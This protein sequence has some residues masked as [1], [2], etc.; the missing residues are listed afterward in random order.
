[1]ITKK[2]K[3]VLIVNDNPLSAEA[4]S[5]LL[6]KIKDSRFKIITDT[7]LS[8]NEACVAS[9]DIPINATSEN[10]DVPYDLYVVDLRM[11]VK[12]G[13]EF[14]EWLRNKRKS[15]K[16]VIITSAQKPSAM[17]LMKRTSNLFIQG[18]YIPIIGLDRVDF[19]QLEET[20]T[21]LLDTK[22]IGIIGGGQIGKELVKIL[23]PLTN[24]FVEK[25]LIYSRNLE[26]LQVEIDD[27]VKKNN[28]P[29]APVYVE[30]D[31]NKLNEHGVDALIVVLKQKGDYKK[32]IINGNSSESRRNGLEINSEAIFNLEKRLY[33]IDFQKPV[34]IAS[35]PP[36]EFC[37]IGYLVGNNKYKRIGFSNDEARAKEILLRDIKKIDRSITRVKTVYVVGDH[38]NG[39]TIIDWENII[40]ENDEGKETPFIK[41]DLKVDEYKDLLTKQ[42]EEE[43]HKGV[44]I[45][46]DITS[47]CETARGIE[48]LLHSMFYTPKRKMS[49]IAFSNGRFVSVPVSFNKN[50]DTITHEELLSHKAK[51]EMRRIYK[52]HDFPDLKDK[53]SIIRKI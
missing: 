53:Y 29:R 11:P 27:F 7:A 48:E 36:A 19:K 24:N 3:K 21:N 18:G 26:K 16:P 33:E 37:T 15:K 34:I 38:R 1:M 6:G 42:V 8:Y 51:Q 49:L 20:V 17:E 2:E 40:F 5:I 32:E 50:L 22:R 4:M 46:G 14:C 25:I 39:A 10:N 28:I 47:I 41:T 45:K 13:I 35:N 9:G 43:G 12:D 31:L 30:S 44:L 23:S 52:E